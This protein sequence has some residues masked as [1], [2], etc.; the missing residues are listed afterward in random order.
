MD[1]RELEELKAEVRSVMQQ[2]GIKRSSHKKEPMKI[3]AFKFD[4]L[5]DVNSNE[6]TR[7]PKHTFVPVD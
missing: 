5:L 1:E 3:K 7:M 4:N 2:H 6:T